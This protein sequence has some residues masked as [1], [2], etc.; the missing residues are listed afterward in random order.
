MNSASAYLSGLALVLNLLAN[1]SAANTIPVHKSHGLARF[2]DLKYPK[3]FTHLKYVSLDAK[4]GGEVRT[5][6]VGTF[7]SVNPY[8][9]TSLS[10][11]NSF[12]F[13]PLGMGYLFLNEPLMA[14]SALYAPS[15]DEPRS[16]YGLIAKS[17]EYPDDNRWIIFNLRKE[18]KFHDKKPV[19]ADD[20]VFSF[21]ELKTNGP[22]KYQQQLSQ[23][24][25][26][27]KLDNHRV[28]FNFSKAG[29]RDQL[30]SAA[31][32]P[33]LP[34]HYW[35]G[36]ELGKASMSPP[37]NSGPYQITDVNPGHSITLTRKA[38]YW[39]KDLPINRG[40]YNVDKIILYF[41]RDPFVALQSFK[42]GDYDVHIEQGGKNWATEYN[43]P[44]VK[45]G[46]IQ[47]KEIPTQLIIGSPM[48]LFNLRN[49]LF[50][51]I[52]VRQAIGLMLDFEWT[53]RALFY[54]AYVR[55]ASYFPNSIYASHNLPVREERHLLS[56]W[57]NQLP[58]ALFSHPFIPPTTKGDGNIR[59][60]QLKA[61]RLLEEAGWQLKT[62]K[63]FN[64]QGRTFSFE[65]LSYNHSFER[66]FNPFVNNVKHLGIDVRLRIIDSGVYTQRVRELDFDMIAH[67]IPF[68]LTIGNELIRY[69]HSDQADHQ[70]TQNLAGIRNPVVD[71]LLELLPTVK[72]QKELVTLAHA[73]DRVLLWNHYGIPLWYY[74]SLRLAYKNIYQWPEVTTD[75][76]MF[77]NTWW[78]KSSELVT[79]DK[80]P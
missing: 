38:D 49:P 40:K 27:D 51:D 15:A 74:G 46:T 5:A 64:Q 43:F 20:V 48:L 66:V 76:P 58:Q 45:D 4:K 47:K 71:Q 52:R 78:V 65:V 23:V 6:A 24:S 21:N 55:S 67:A 9:K 3:N 63:L 80:G 39:G 2:D 32:M 18:A 57:K 31:E 22:V 11:L 17:V 50:K 56:Q 10:P 79:K 69:F 37:L 26:V 44:A 53:N 25:S 7:E 1:Q 8:A 35:Q 60:N 61:L 75:F 16:A 33:V 29:S 70:D 68:G 36:R 41:H 14:G 62:E 34:K 42:K 19:L 73:L 30:F 12:P 77:L 72:T 59:Q 54:N 28:R 13:G